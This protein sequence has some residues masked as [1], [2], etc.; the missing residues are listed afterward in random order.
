[1][2]EEGRPINQACRH[3]CPHC[4]DAHP[5]G[6]LRR[7]FPVTRCAF[8]TREARGRQWLGPRRPARSELAARVDP[9][10]APRL[11]S[12]NAVVPT[13]ALH[14]GRPRER[15]RRAHAVRRRDEVRIAPRAPRDGAGGRGARSSRRRSR[16]PSPRAPRSIRIAALLSW[17]RRAEARRRRRS[18]APPPTRRRRRPSRSP[19]RCSRR[20]RR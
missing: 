12:N 19:R 8:I 15:R 17:R 20:T 9:V 14:H 4:R 3:A 11:K 10:A 16:R 2:G 5:L 6:T 18:R 7:W 1:M 13:A